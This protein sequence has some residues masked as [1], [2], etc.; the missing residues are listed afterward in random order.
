MAAH[1]TSSG[2]YT[3][4]RLRQLKE[5]NRRNTEALSEVGLKGSFKP[6][7]EED[8]G[9]AT[10]GD[11]DVPGARSDEESGQAIPTPAEIEAA[12][13]KRRKLSS[14]PAFIPVRG[15]AKLSSVAGLS[16]G[17]EGERV[18]FK[19]YD[20]GKGVGDMAGGRYVREIDEPA[21]HGI[22]A[23]VVSVADLDNQAKE[24]M[25][26]I[27]R[28]LRRMEGGEVSRD[29]EIS[30]LRE[31][32][33]FAEGKQANAKGRLDSLT[34][35]YVFLEQTQ[36]YLST[37]CECLGDKAGDIEALEEDIEGVQRKIDD[38]LRR[39]RP[40]ARDVLFQ[41]MQAGI[42]KAMFLGGTDLSGPDAQ[43]VAEEL[44]KKEADL[45]DAH[46]RRDDDGDGASLRRVMEQDRKRYGA[47][48]GMSWEF[49][50][51]EEDGGH[52]AAEDEEGDVLEEKLKDLFDSSHTLL[53]DVDED[54]CSLDRIARRLGHF[55]EFDRGSYS[56]A[57]VPESLPQ[58]VSPFVR[59]ELLQWADSSGGKAAV[60]APLGAMEWYR[61]LK[62][63]K[64][65]PD[66]DLLRTLTEKLLLP[67]LR[68]V[69]AHLW[70]PANLHQTRALRSAV[71]DAVVGCGVEGGSEA[72]QEVLLAVRNAY[73]WD[74]ENANAGIPMWPQKVA[75]SVPLSQGFV[76]HAV[77]RAA[78]K[79]AGLLL[80]EGLID[81]GALAG[82]AI[83]SI[84]EGAMLPY[85]RTLK[86]DVGAQA[87]IGGFLCEAVPEG[88]LRAV[89]E[90]VGALVGFVRDCLAD[91]Q[92]AAMGGQ[93]QH[94]EG[95][96]Q[97][98]QFL[99]LVD[100]QQQG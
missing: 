28:A 14:A 30:R 38:G 49:L 18:K 68:F 8:R 20:E 67:K 88:W 2:E 97:M 42:M 33:E 81:Q 26:N 19:F 22:S 53:A 99:R 35:Q 80:W 34:E 1:M 66:S 78:H 6:E 87:C 79:F 10:P 5:A 13:L 21:A 36:Q 96:D 54:F 91:C 63:Y 93:Q 62:S 94:R 51:A 90:E 25:E 70:D 77:R 57:Y 85:L 48:R 52:R 61:V 43:R 45:V 72:L 55:K 27:S 46:C 76:A 84:F 86:S 16:D 50:N 83:K 11:D 98:R 100:E 65:D 58:L 23:A 92:A 95:V 47:F 89:P 44:E 12:K 73:H 15:S 7:G 32:V 17:E 74:H 59:L 40:L 24:A 29:G 60:S 56:Q 31:K 37:L 64:A 39:L 75:R 69:V 71:D 41:S 3:A 82:M 4:E 9:L